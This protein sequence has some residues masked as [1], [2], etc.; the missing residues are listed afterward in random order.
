MTNEEISVA[1]NDWRQGDVL[2]GDIDLPL[3]DI[4]EDGHEAVL[5]GSDG[6]VLL[7]QSCD[8]IRA[9]DKRPYLHVAALVPVTAQ[10]L[11]RIEA[12]R[13]IRYLYVPG[14][15]DRLLVADLDLTATIDKRIIVGRERVVGCTTDRERRQLAATI[16]RHRQRYAFPDEFNDAL[17]PL[18]RWVERGAGANS[19]KGRFIDAILEIRVTTSSWDN[20][21]LFDPA[22]WWYD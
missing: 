19:D 12:G 4:G 6:A 9:Y 15:R 20:P 2:L 13:E 1:L 8:I 22:M 10:E 11:Q 21:E 16:A 14:L 17:K 7:T 3:L 18:R 5:S